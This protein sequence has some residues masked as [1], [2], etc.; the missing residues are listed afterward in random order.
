MVHRT[1]LRERGYRYVGQGRIYNNLLRE[2]FIFMPTVLLRRECLDHVGVFDVT[3]CNCE[4]VDLWF[5]MADR[6]E[7]GFIDE[8]L[9][10]RHQHGANV[11]GHSEDY[12][13]APV[14]LMGRL[15]RTNSDPERRA[16]IRERL[17]SMFYN[18]GYYYFSVGRMPECRENM[19]KAISAG[20]MPGRALKY[21]ALSLLPA[22][23]IRGLKGGHIPFI[24]KQGDS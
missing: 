11:T 7:V 21:Y 20:G 5:R 13:K 3:M 14:L 19:L 10:I 8:P 2:G 17:Q 18:L 22:V 16:I 9:A 6:Y 4:D 23:V 15:Y 24:S 1:Y 12:L